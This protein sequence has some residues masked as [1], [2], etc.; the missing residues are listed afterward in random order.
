MLLLV[1]LGCKPP[2]HYY[3]TDDSE[4]PVGDST[5]SVDTG[6]GTN[7]LTH[8][9]PI[10]TYETTSGDFAEWMDAEV[11]EDGRTVL[12]GVTGL[13]IVDTETGEALRLPEGHGDGR[14]YR[15]AVDNDIVYMASRADSIRRVDISGDDPVFMDNGPGT[16]PT[17]GYHEDISAEGG[18]VLLGGLDEGLKVLDDTLQTLATVEATSAFGVKKFGDRG[19]YTDADE[20]VLLDLTD[21][22]NPVELDR[23][24]TAGTGRDIDVE[25]T[26]V[27][28][29]MGGSGVE[30]FRLEDDKLL[31]RGTLTLPGSAFGVDVDGDWAW[32]AAWETV[33][34]A[35]LGAGG[36]VMV[37]HEDPVQSAMGLGARDGVAVIGDWMNITYMKRAGDFMGPEVHDPGPILYQ[38]GA[39][40]PLPVLYTNYGAETLEMELS[41]GSDWS[42][43]ETSLTIE[44]GASELVTATPGATQTM[45]IDWTSNDPD[46]ATGHTNLDTATTGVGTT[47]PDFSLLGFTP[48]ETA[49]DTYSLS[50]YAGTNV[51]IAYF[52]TW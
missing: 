14:A 34:L 9:D 39:T 48:P 27:A 42:L 44:P 1:A 32:I 18:I 26:R 45:R 3:L 17:T 19:L 51:F 24:T 35:W 38:Q 29:A 16:Q 30:I 47:H 22:T 43:S 23:L 37:G 7:P 8:G 50:D 36:P 2:Q 28:V 6:D 4:T 12:I 46:E 31:S 20:L 15:L 33:G 10:T 5:P 52:T 41:I 11:L 40:D 13:A 25:G 21:P 49:T